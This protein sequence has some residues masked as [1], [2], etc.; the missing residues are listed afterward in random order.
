MTIKAL[1]TWLGA[2]AASLVGYSALVVAELPETRPFQT[3]HPD[4]GD[5][6]AIEENRPQFGAVVAGRNDTALVGMPTFAGGG[7]VAVFNRPGRVWL[8]AG[9]LPCPN[10]PGGCHFVHSIVL[11]DNIAVV[12]AETFLAVFKRV[13]GKWRLTQKIN[14]PDPTA[15]QF[16]TSQSVRYEYP[17]I[18]AAAYHADAAPS[19]LYVFEISAAGKLLN[20]TRLAAS[21]GAPSDAFGITAYMALPRIVVSGAGA[22]YV[23]NRTSTGWVE[24]QKLRLPGG[25]FGHSV[26]IDKG[27]ILV[28]A[29][30]NRRA[31]GQGFP[32]QRGGVV[33][34]FEQQNGVW[35][36][37]DTLQPSIEEHSRYTEFGQN[38]VMF[39]ERAAIGATDTAVDGIIAFEYERTPQGLK[40]TS[41]ARGGGDGGF[42]AR[43]ALF[44]N[45]LMLGS[46]VESDGSN[47]GHVKMFNLSSSPVHSLVSAASTVV[48]PEAREPR[49]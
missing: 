9:N 34:A 49:T 13:D 32:F 1:K 15:I 24:R 45:N 30:S 18:T 26:A 27:L 22:A 6:I 40:A 29:P 47:I 19:A 41:I 11:R 20:T 25:D 14:S 48:G 23:F 42:G 37:S 16:G 38:I 33:H 35:T 43:L 12:G 46:P 3:L 36:L 5:L 8:R 17:F 7:R 28:G 10:D 21:D 4:Q 31:G 44:N 39:G 2:A